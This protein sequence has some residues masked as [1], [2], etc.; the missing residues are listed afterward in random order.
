MGIKTAKVVQRFVCDYCK[1]VFEYES[2]MSPTDKV[3][4]SVANKL[5][6]LVCMSDPNGGRQPYETTYCNDECAINGIRARDHRVTV[7]LKVNP[8]SVSLAAGEADVKAAIAGDAA[9]RKMKKRTN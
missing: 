8:P 2:P 7:Q 6:E 4:E 9:V 3:P 1:D 5:K